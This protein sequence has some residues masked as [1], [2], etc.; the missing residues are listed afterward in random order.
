MSTNIWLLIAIFP[1]CRE[2][3]R[4]LSKK[5][6]ILLDTARILSPDF[7]EKYQIQPISQVQWQIA[8]LFLNSNLL[9]QWVLFLMKLDLAE[10][11]R[12]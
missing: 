3:A 5:T 9:I 12:Y 10:F 8:N 1:I 7:F 4:T 6:M 11:F 2:V